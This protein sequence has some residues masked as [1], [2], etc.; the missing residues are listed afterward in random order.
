MYKS[1]YS[2]IRHKELENSTFSLL[3]TKAVLVE[4]WGL[5]S[6]SQKRRSL[7]VEKR[8]W[9]ADKDMLQQAVAEQ[10]IVCGI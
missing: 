8:W 4:M 2:Y 1:T 10:K 7:I 5:A 6:M 9:A 3:G